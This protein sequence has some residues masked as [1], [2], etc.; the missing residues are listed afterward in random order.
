[1]EKVFDK[2]R[3]SYSSELLKFI[4]INKYR[5]E[6]I[7]LETGFGGIWLTRTQDVT[8][9]YEAALDAYT[10]TER[11]LDRKRACC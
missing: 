5:A 6:T 7:T 10:G 3:G 4:A 8:R 2:H 9:R 1:M 11:D